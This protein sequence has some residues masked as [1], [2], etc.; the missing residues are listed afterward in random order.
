MRV[1]DS[2]GTDRYCLVGIVGVV[3]VV[4]GGVVVGSAF[5]W[6]Y[7]GQTVTDLVDYCQRVKARVVVDVRLNAISRKKG[8]SKTALSS[9]LAD[10]G[11]EYVH[12]RSLG[13]PKDNRPGFAHPGTAEA[14]RAHERFREEVLDSPKA[15]AQLEDAA[16]LVAQSNVVFLCYE[17]AP[18]CCHRHLIIERLSELT[19]NRT[20]RSLAA[21]SLL[22]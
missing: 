18:D 19:Q 3:P 17:H 16:V 20:F 2:L 1:V 13:N 7:E 21:A 5:G 14:R 10:E 15:R 9:A 11:I 8:F 12:L 22:G 4:L 6:G